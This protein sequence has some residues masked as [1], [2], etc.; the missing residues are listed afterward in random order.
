[1]KSISVFIF[2]AAYLAVFSAALAIA[3]AEAF[4]TTKAHA[5]LDDWN[6]F[7]FSAVSWVT[8][9]IVFYGDDENGGFRRRAVAAGIAFS[10]TLV[11]TAGTFAYYHSHYY[12]FPQIEGFKVL[13]FLYIF[14]PVPSLFIATG[15]SLNQKRSTRRRR[16]GIPL[17]SV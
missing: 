7:V 15:I 16:I 1:M 9:L 6:F 8:C 11:L 14:L 17:S 5:F 3:A 2:R 13:P 12:E 4:F 10:T